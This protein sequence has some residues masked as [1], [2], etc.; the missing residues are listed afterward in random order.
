[1]LILFTTLAGLYLRG[2]IDTCNKNKVPVERL[3]GSM[4]LSFSSKWQTA[5]KQQLR[6]T[7][8]ETKYL[9]SMFVLRLCSVV[10]KWG[11]ECVT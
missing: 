6:G 7:L 1:M 10:E 4:T 11:E 8:R 2:V 5:I 3:D 9:H